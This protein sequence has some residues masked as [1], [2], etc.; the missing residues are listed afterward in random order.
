LTNA[1]DDENNMMTRPQSVQRIRTLALTAGLLLGVAAATFVPQLAHAN[2]PKAKAKR[3]L[4]EKIIELPE[5]TAEQLQAAERVLVGH[6]QC[7]F[8]KQVSVARSEKHHGY[9]DLGLGKQTWVMKPIQSS[10]GAVRL[11]DIKGTALLIQI[12]TKSMLMD[13]KSGHRLVDGCTQESQREAEA[14]LKAH[15]RP[16]AFNLNPDKAIEASK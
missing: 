1:S 11:E 9:F 6:Y 8:G 3:T 4:V 7:E 14:D 13:V 12:L 2:L 10:T 15:P 16:S 5:A